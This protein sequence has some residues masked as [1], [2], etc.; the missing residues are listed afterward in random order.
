M[1]SD[2]QLRLEDEIT[3]VEIELLELRIADRRLARTVRNA[4]H[5]MC[6]ALRETPD[7][8]VAIAKRQR[9]YTNHLAAHGRFQVRMAHVMTRLRDLQRQLA[10]LRRLQSEEMIVGMTVGYGSMVSDLLGDEASGGGQ[11][12]EENYM[13]DGHDTWAT[14]VQNPGPRR[15]SGTVNDDLISRLRRF[16]SGFPGEKIGSSLKDFGYRIR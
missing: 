15:R 12:F 14:F 13:F 2:A 6:T 16:P 3:D 10:E 9:A 1:C 8:F 4:E 11:R 5:G 7:D